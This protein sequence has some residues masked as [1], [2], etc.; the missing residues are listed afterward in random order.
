MTQTATRAFDVGVEQYNL[1][2]RLTFSRRCTE[3]C[4]NRPQPAHCLFSRLVGN[5]QGCR[6]VR[7][8]H[9]IDVNLD[10]GWKGAV[11]Y[12]SIRSSRYIR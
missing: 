1:T 5:K 2:R 6:C 8:H 7:L 10:P 11:V 12:S 4:I 3:I 9:V